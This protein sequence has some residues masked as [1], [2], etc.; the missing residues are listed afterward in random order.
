VADANLALTNRASVAGRSS[1][2]TPWVKMKRHWQL[3]LLISLVPTAFLLVFNYWPMVGESS[4]PFAI[5]A[6]Y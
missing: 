6:R 5:T 4:W 2:R 3:Y 1:T